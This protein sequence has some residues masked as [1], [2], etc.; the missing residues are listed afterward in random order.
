MADNA[1]LL[2]DEILPPVDMRQWVIIQ[3]GGFKQSTART[4]TV[5]FI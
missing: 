5:T 4:G 2:V 1:V 3:K